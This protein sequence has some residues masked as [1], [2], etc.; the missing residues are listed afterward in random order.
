MAHVRSGRHGWQHQKLRAKTQR[1][2]DAEGGA[3][4]WRWAAGE[5]SPKCARFIPPHTPAAWHLGHAADRVTYAGPECV[6]CN[7]WDAARVTNGMRS[8][9][10]RERVELDW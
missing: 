4:C 8:G 7:L 2:I 9:R 1:L 3:T 10:T 6:A 5:P